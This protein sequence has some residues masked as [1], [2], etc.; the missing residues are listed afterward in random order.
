MKFTDSSK[1]FL[2][3]EGDFECRSLPSIAAHACPVRCVV[4][5]LSGVVLCLGPEDRR[6]MANFFIVLNEDFD[7]IMTLEGLV[8]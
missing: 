4:C 7:I 8:A 1:C 5:Y 2:K 6:R 3:N